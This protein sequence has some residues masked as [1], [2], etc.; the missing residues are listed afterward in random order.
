MDRGAW[1]DVTQQ[2]QQNNNCRKNVPLRNDIFLFCLILVFN[3]T[4]QKQAPKV[5]RYITVA[6]KTPTLLF[7]QKQQVNIWY[8]LPE[9]CFQLTVS[10]NPT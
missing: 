8:I 4:K 7:R 3:P 1:W 2:Q 9:T 10:K 6:I 5:S